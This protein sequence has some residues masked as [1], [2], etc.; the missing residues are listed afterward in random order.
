MKSKGGT[1][2]NFTE[3]LQRGPSSSPLSTTVMRANRRQNRIAHVGNFLAF[4][5]A[6]NM[7]WYE[8]TFINDMKGSTPSFHK[9]IPG[10][11]Q[12]S[13]PGLLTVRYLGMPK[14]LSISSED[15]V[16]FWKPQKHQYPQPL[17]NAGSSLSV[18]VDHW[19]ASL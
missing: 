17:R 15:T 11:Q 6:S 8:R 4:Y 2:P 12:P 13:V 10:W 18:T 16:Q 9:L 1:A 3:I 19:N 14:Y 5:T 7:C